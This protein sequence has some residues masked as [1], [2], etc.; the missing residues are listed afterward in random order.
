MKI[1]IVGGGTAGITMAARLRNELSPSYTIS[2]IE[3]SEY[4]YYQ[5]YWTLNGAGIGKK[6]DTRRTTASVM[7]NGVEWIKDRCQQIRPDKKEVETLEHGTLNYDILVVAPGIQI[8]WNEIEGLKDSIGK[9][10]VCSNYSY[11]YVDYTW[12]FLQE[13]K[14]GNALFTF[15]NS[16][17][18]CGGAPQ[19]IMYLVEDYVRKHGNRDNV[20]IE[21]ASP[22]QAIF[23]IPKYKAALEKIIKERDI[24]T[25]FHI[26]LEK[27]DG[28]NNKAYFRDLQTNELIEKDYSF[29]HVVPPM[30]APDFLKDSDL[31]DSTGWIDV[32][33]HTLQHKK[34]SNVFAIGDATNVPTAKTGAAVRK[35]AP[36]LVENIVK[37]I[38]N[39]TNFNTSY[40]GYTSCPIVTGYG[41][42]ILA[43]FDYDGNP[44]ETFPFDQAKPRWSMYFLKAHILPIVYWHGMLK[45][46]M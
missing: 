10:G 17:L 45:G 6:E 46:R 9:K 11:D 29:I 41:Q 13:L 16:P 40:N 18:K 30:S 34:Y 20:T 3:P 35:Q 36:V 15:P 44:C 8:N 43:E 19:K 31:L 42:L 32:D 23:G 33:K 4:H 14:N 27:L 39:K 1:I 26:N 38:N 2:V 37:F 28:E 22:G 25:H 24:K 21:F 12:K 7:P 5:P